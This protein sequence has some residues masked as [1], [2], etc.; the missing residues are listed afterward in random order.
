VATEQIQTEADNSNGSEQGADDRAAKIKAN[1]KKGITSR[2]L[3]GHRFAMTYPITQGPKEVTGDRLL[4]KCFKYK[5]PVTSFTPGTGVAVEKNEEGDDTPVVKDGNVDFARTGLVL[6][7][8]GGSADKSQNIYYISLPI[9]QEINDSNALTWGDDSMNIFQLAGLAIAQGVLN[10]TVEGQNNGNEMSFANAVEYYS[11]AALGSLSSIDPKTQQALLNAISGKAINAIGGNLSLSS[12]V[13]RSSGV[14]LNNNLELLFNGVNLRTFPFTV[15]FTP[16]SQKEA[17]VVLEIIRAL[18]SSMAAKKNA[19]QGQGGIFLRA[20]D[21]FS[22]RYLHNGKDHP[23]LNRIKDC[24]LTGLNVNYTGAGTYA[25]Y[26][27]GAPVSMS[28][29]MTFKELN[30]VYHEDYTD[31]IG[32]VG[33]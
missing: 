10:K 17:Q 26:H 19:E 4:I 7:N 32:G 28:M 13:G 3:N 27:D 11:G 1:I 5:P 24:A 22:L 9:P 33:Y 2:K 23:F 25:S 29:N 31:N 12:A 20:P 8:E 30:P 16:R 14:A 6:K 21:V 15:T 18:K